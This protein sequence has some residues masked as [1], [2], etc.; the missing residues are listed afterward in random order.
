M[1]LT[2]PSSVSFL[3]AL[4]LGIAGIAG[5]MGFLAVVAPYA[6][7][8]VTAAFVVLALACLLRGV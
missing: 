6:F 8:L 4:V 1:T 7:W 5:Q 3:L 2:P